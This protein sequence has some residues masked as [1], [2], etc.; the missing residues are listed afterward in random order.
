MAVADADAVRRV[1]ERLRDRE[2][3]I[4][5]SGDGW[6]EM[7]ARLFVTD[8]QAL[9]QRLEAL[10]A[11]VCAGAARRRQQC[12]APMASYPPSWSP[13]WPRPPDCVRCSRRPGPNRT[14]PRQPTWR[15]LCA[16]DLTCRAPGCDRPATDS[17]LDHTI[18]YAD[19]GATHPSN[20]KCLCRLHHQNSHSVAGV[21]HAAHPERCSTRDL[22]GGMAAA[23]TRITDLVV[24]LPGS[25]YSSTTAPGWRGRFRRCGQRTGWIPCSK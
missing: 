23:W 25:R 4:W 17:D 8:A 14:T 5:A 11:T 2:V 22:A 10:T 19:G 12:S 9:D 7:T 1:R 13:S 15:P 20:V 18:A 16:R 24:S 21:A 6:A 3:A